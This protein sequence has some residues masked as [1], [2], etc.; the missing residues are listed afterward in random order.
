M[1]RAA[2]DFAG[3]A[4]GGRVELYE[5]FYLAGQPRNYTRDHIQ[6]MGEP[7]F[8]TRFVGRSI[9]YELQGS[10]EMEPSA[11]GIRWKLEFPIHQNVLRA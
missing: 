6:A 11:A 7:G 5:K 1:F 2:W 4:L 10:A 3:S 8:G 9:E